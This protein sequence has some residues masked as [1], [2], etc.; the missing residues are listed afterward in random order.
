MSECYKESE[1]CFNSWGL[2]QVVTP[3]LSPSP[4]KKS[5]EE[6]ADIL[7]MRNQDH[8]REGVY[9]DDQMSSSWSPAFPTLSQ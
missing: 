1:D 9:L 2:V 5:L 8:T 7:H 4:D 3:L 6:M